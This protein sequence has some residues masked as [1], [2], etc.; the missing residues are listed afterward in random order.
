MR[1]FLSCVVPVQCKRMS[2]ETFSKLEVSIYLLTLVCFFQILFFDFLTQF[3]YCRKVLT[4]IFNKFCVYM[5]SVRVNSSEKCHFWTTTL[6]TIKKVFSFKIR[7]FSNLNYG[8]KHHESWLFA[9]QN[10]IFDF[11]HTKKTI[12]EGAV[13]GTNK[14]NNCPT[15]VGL[16]N[17][18]FCWRRWKY[19]SIVKH[20]KHFIQI[21]WAYYFDW[22]R[23]HIVCHI[24]VCFWLFLDLV[25]CKVN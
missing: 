16:K 15:F 19:T 11:L 9:K 18:Y 13:D 3:F 22:F 25:A 6:A 7:C 1:Q 14:S 2:G 21:M 23:L 10:G 24:Y 20:R 5:Q 17:W 8:V 12:G 4:F